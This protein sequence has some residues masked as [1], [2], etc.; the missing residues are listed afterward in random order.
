[1]SVCDGVYGLLLDAVLAVLPLSDLAAASAI[2]LPSKSP[3][4]SVIFLISF[5]EAVL[6]ASAADYLA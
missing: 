5:I 6:S 4:A 3:V 1:M 2:L